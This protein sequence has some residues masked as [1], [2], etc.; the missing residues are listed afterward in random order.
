MIT[1]IIPIQC[2][3]PFIMTHKTVYFVPQR[4]KK[5]RPVDKWCTAY[6]LNGDTLQA[7]AGDRGHFFR[8]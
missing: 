7:V 1:I 6:V 3:R 4:D 2:S 8:I 5:P